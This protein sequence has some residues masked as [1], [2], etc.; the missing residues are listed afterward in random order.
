[1]AIVDESL[2]GME[3]KGIVGNFIQAWEFKRTMECCGKNLTNSNFIVSVAKA[4]KS[5]C[6]ES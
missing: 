3:V 1:M 4:L 6:L 2:R 5:F